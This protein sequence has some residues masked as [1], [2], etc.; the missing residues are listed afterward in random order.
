MWTINTRTI[1]LSFTAYHPR[2]DRDSGLRRLRRL[3]NC[4]R[5]IALSPVSFPK[6]CIVLIE[7]NIDSEADL[8][9]I[10]FLS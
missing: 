4:L 1:P 2:Y 3:Q 8:E 7:L 10:N 5:A 6:S 9:N